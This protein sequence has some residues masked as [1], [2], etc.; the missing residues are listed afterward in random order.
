MKKL[1]NELSNL[2]GVSGFEYRIADEIVNMFKPYADE[3]YTDSLGNI[4]AHKKSKN[5][6]S[7]KL[8]IEAHYDEI[9]LIVKSITKEGFVT[10]ANIGGVDNRI[11]PSLEVVIHGKEDVCGVI[12]IKPEYLLEKDK[13]I[14][15]KELAIDTG[16]SAPKVKELISIGDSISIAQSVGELGKKQWSGKS[17]DDRASVAIL[18]S[19]MKQIADKDLPVDIYAVATV[20]EEVGCRGAKTCAFSI[21]PDMAIAIDVTHGI[22]PDNSENAFKTGEGIVISVGPNLHPKLTNRLVDVCNNKNIA[23]NIEAVGGD[24]G[25]DAWEIQ[26]AREGIPTAL[27]SIPL[28]Y[29]H[30]SVETLDVSDVESATS[31]IF[32]F[33]NGLEE[34]LEWLK[35]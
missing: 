11:L 30:T 3:V 22:T 15:L 31:L 28:K 2:R 17:L 8:L 26:V 32:E 13:S 9:G 35:L 10:F 24:T 34:D 1:I 5:I 25:T 21:N 12:G 4:I 16:L 20:Q 19:V 33:I 14:K 27:L 23:H 18:I 7:P 6:N 29:M